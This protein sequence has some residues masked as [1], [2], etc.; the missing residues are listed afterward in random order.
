MLTFFKIVFIVIM[1]LAGLAG[2][3]I[4]CTRGNE[5]PGVED[6]EP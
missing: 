6:V 3:I 5:M 2:A 4:L 1:L